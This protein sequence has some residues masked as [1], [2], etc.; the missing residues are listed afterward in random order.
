MYAFLLKKLKRDQKWNKWDQTSPYSFIVF[1]IHFILHSTN[2]L[3]M[4]YHESRVRRCVGVISF[5]TFFFAKYCL[6][7]VKCINILS[8]I[9][10]YK[11]VLKGFFLFKHFFVVHSTFDSFN[12]KWWISYHMVNYSIIFFF[13]VDNFH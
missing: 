9:Y 13:F 3:W 8:D 12:T 6:Y 1:L 7:I 11:L 5:K 2:T 4:I 10:V